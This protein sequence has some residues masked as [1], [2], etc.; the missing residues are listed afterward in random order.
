MRDWSDR[1]I[2]Y[3]SIVVNA[4]LCWSLMAGSGGP[5]A[6]QYGH[7]YASLIFFLR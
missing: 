3:L 6:V 2:P 1:L 5:N 4:L 7:K